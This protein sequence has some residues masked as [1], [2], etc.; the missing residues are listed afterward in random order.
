[1]IGVFYLPYQDMDINCTNTKLLEDDIPDI[2]KYIGLIVK[3]NQKYG[4]Q[5][6]S[7]VSTKY[8]SNMSENEYEK[9]KRKYK[10][11]KTGYIPC[12]CNILNKDGKSLTEDELTKI[13]AA[14]NQQCILIIQLDKTEYELDEIFNKELEDWMKRTKKIQNIPLSRFDKDPNKAKIKQLAGYPMKNFRL[15]TENGN[16]VILNNVRFIQNKGIV[17][18]FTILVGNTTYVSQQQISEIANKQSR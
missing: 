5:V 11:Q 2:N 13:S 9:W 8:S 14:P 10:A 18:S 17:S 7:M 15:Q 1:M 6:F 4:S 12:R 16:F 3:D